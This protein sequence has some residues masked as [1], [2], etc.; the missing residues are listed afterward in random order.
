MKCKPTTNAIAGARYAVHDQQRADNADDHPFG[1]GSDTEPYPQG[2][3]PVLRLFAGREGQLVRGPDQLD[4]VDHED[5]REDAED[6]DK[7]DAAATGRPYS[8]HDAHRRVKNAIRNRPIATNRA[9]G[10]VA[11]PLSTGVS[12]NAP[13]LRLPLVDTAEHRLE[14][15]DW[16]SVDCLEAADVEAYPIKA[17]DPYPM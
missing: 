2:A 11:R 5:H 6:H 17:Q 9:T 7:C 1:G 15:N 3:A 8:D 16:R 13:P 14:V 10:P 12:A 4:T